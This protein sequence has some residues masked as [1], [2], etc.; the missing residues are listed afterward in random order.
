[1]QIDLTTLD[2]NQKKAVLH[3]HGPLLV[4]AGAGSGKTRVLTFRIARLIKEKLCKPHN[5]LAVTFTNKAAKEMKERLAALTSR[6]TVK[7]MTI[8]TFH[9]LGAK[10]LKN[11]GDAISIPKNF[12][13]IDENERV[14]A[15]KTIIRS[16][17]RSTKNED[18]HALGTQISLVK[19]ASLTPEEFKTRH[20]EKRKMH[21]IYNTYHTL[22]RKRHCVDFD[23]LLLLPL[24]L[25]RTCPA[26]LEEYR[27]QYQFLSI[28]E[29]QD[30][31]AVQMHLCKLL[32]HPQNNIMAVGDDDQG[33]YSWRG[34]EI[35]NILQFSKS[36]TGCKTVILNRNY[37][38]TEQIVRGASAVIERNAQRKA[39]KIL[40]VPGIGSPILTYKAEDELDEIQWIITTIIDH[41][42]SKKFT[43]NDHAILLRTNALMARFEDEFRIQRI[44][45]RVQGA[46]S[47]FDRK[48]VKDI[49]AY[50]R[51]FANTH[52]EVSFMRVLKVPH[53]GITGSTLER[54]EELAGMRKISLWE[55][56]EQYADARDIQDVQKE[57]LQQLVDF[58]N[59]HH[60]SFQQGLLSETLEQILA[61]CN[62]IELLEKAYKD[63][64]SLQIRIENVKEI[65]HTLALYE[66]RKR[67]EKASLYNYLHECALMSHDDPDENKK[68]NGVVLMTLHKAK[69]LEFPVVFLPILDDSVFPSPKS[70][71]EGKI[72]EERRLFYVG[73]TRAQKKLILS[74]PRTKLF[75]K[76]TTPVK[77]CRFIFEIPTDYCD[78]RFGEKEDEQI[79]QSTLDFFQEM[80]RKFAK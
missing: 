71:A 33:I 26:I 10:I 80:K 60:S 78:S 55:A 54:L 35:E 1:M 16:T 23:D 19:N 7:E 65:V 28:D 62:Y 64:P 8:A 59:R 51:F 22:L 76:N 44:P 68:R 13:I 79:E 38:S 63:T 47:F 72:E 4:L 75:R 56:F 48:E 14:S 46:M 69:G 37:R 53:K 21:R 5:I 74:C 57:R 42:Q 66:K 9:S 45:Y 43:F 40:S 49:L 36:F 61:E 18:H 6:K 24:Q 77:P 34:A 11:H 52:D 31:N 15:L 39:K 29:F 17:A 3:N 70:C 73:M 30:T 50:L 58:F 2:E 20:P 67:P 25:F 32:A 12:T 27:K 41:H